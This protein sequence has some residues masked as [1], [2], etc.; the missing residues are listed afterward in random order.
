MKYRISW[1]LAVLVMLF[2]SCDKE[3]QSEIDEELIKQYIS[4]NNLDATRHSSGIYYVITKEGIGSMY[5]NINSTVEVRYKGYLLDGTVFDQTIG[6]QTREWPLYNLIPG[7]QYGIPL[8]RKDGE[9]LFLIPSELAYGPDD[10][11]GIPGNSVLAFEI[12][13]VDF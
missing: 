9:G 1:I 2:V 4:D 6:D 12:E 11:T 7:W 3:D 10:R 5:P 8:L 13:L